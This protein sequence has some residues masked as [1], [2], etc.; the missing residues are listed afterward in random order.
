MKPAENLLGMKLSGNWTVKDIVAKKPTATG[1]HFS[2]GYLVENEDGR[3]AFLKAM[4]YITAFQAP[5]TAEVLQAMTSA[6]LFEKDVCE[7]CRSHSLRRVV[8]AIDSGTI[9]ASPGQP[10]SKVE[11]LIFELAD[12]DIRAHLDAQQGFDLAFVL[13]SLHNVAAGLEQLHRAGIAHQ[14]LKPSNV[15]VFQGEEGSKVS[16]LGRAWSRDHQ[17]PHD[18]YPVAGDWGYAPPELLYREIP[19]DAGMRRFGCDTF[20][21]GSLIVF[22]FTRG[23]MTGLLTNHLAPEH[24]AYNWTGTYAEVLPYVQVAFGMALQDFE[25]HTPSQFT[26]NL[27]EMVKQLCEPDPSRRGHPLNRQGDPHSLERFISKL[28]LLAHKAETQLIGGTR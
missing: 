21:L 19:S 8:H 26:T 4:D 2:T 17:A 27:T 23:H 22:M 20:H 13:R 6:Y 10:A 7:K 1:G 18:I 16:D 11:Y 15:L 24:R 25:R 5:N 3:K 12:G 9:E 28:D 14:D